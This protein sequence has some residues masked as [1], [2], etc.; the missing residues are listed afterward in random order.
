M[1]VITCITD[2]LHVANVDAHGPE[3]GHAAMAAPIAAITLV[4]R[5]SD[6]GQNAPLTIKPP[7]WHTGDDWLRWSF[8]QM[9]A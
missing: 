8:P 2:C 4:G 5:W 1:A 9:R 3:V 7:K 6:D